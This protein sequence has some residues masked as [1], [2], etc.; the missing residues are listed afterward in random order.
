MAMNSTKYNIDMVSVFFMN[1]SF[2][3]ESRHPML[4]NKN[5]KL[6]LLSVT[7]GANVDSS[8]SSTG[9]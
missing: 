5:I 6:Q 8:F 9:L 1:V 7:G 2:S 4:R 3:I